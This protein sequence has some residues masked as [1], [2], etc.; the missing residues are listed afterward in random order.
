[1]DLIMLGT[2][3]AVATNCYNTCFILNNEDNYFLVDG[4]GGSGLFRQLEHAGIDWK[5][6]GEV[7]V[8][9]KHMDHLFGVL[10][11]IRLV[12]QYSV[13]GDYD[14]EL[15]IRG[16][17]EVISIINDFI[18]MLLRPVELECMGTVVHLI[19]VVSGEHCIIN[20]HDVVFFD[21]GSDRTLQYGFSMI[22]DDG[23]KFSC[24]G[25]EPFHECVRDYVYGSKWLLHEAFCLFSDVDVF[26]PYEK[27]HSTVKD[28]CLVA[29]SLSVGN[30][31]LY[32]TVDDDL[33]SR[34]KRFY[35]EGCRF[36]SGKLFIPDDLEVFSL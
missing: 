15:F 12:C 14:G 30:L 2:G 23:S 17:N 8:T 1:M 34:K 33:C 5:D 36:F 9:H 13:R 20:G 27:N 19:S 11:L 29:E 16:H 28:A 31:V 32:H 35:D 22:L 4:G 21:V 7:F 26:N 18:A 3:N 24:C 10:W 6:I 25:D